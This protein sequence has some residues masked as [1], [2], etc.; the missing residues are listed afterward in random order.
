M[1]GAPPESIENG[2]GSD[3]PRVVAV[4]D[5]GAEPRL[6]T[7]TVAGADEPS[8]TEPNETEVGLTEISGSDGP[9]VPGTAISTSCPSRGDEPSMP[10]STTQRLVEI[11]S[12][13]GAQVAPAG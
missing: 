1:K 8:T 4:T 5:S 3:P 2:E 10:R 7:V 12:L 9:P 13:P 6:V 11:P